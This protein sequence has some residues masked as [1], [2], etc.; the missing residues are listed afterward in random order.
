MLVHYCLPKTINLWC[1]RKV[2]FMSK[3]VLA[4]PRG[5]LFVL[6]AGILWST[7]GVAVNYMY[8]STPTTA[9][10]ILYYRF[11]F[12][13]PVL[14]MLLL[15][16]GVFSPIKGPD[17]RAMLVMGSMLAASQLCY[18][19]A[20]REI[21]VAVATLIAICVP[22]I[23]VALAS[24]FLFK[25]ALTK[26]VLTALCLAALG[27]FLLIGFEKASEPSSLWGVVI[28]LGSAATFAAVILAGR[29]LAGYDR[30]LQANAVTIGFGTLLLTPIASTLGI[31]TSFTA[32][33]WS[34][35]VY[36]GVVTTALSYWLFVEG[37]RS[38]SA[39]EASILTLIDPLV[40]TA[41]AY[42]L[43]DERLEPT[44]LIGAALLL[45]AFVIIS[46]R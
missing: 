2:F 27:V 11:L 3:R 43:I 13:T 44:G 35:L 31:G 17:L 10:T 32:L 14:V 4:R 34:L 28:A 1:L 45:A 23:F 20:L 12:A 6:A 22:P 36:L 41:L 37:M 38:V 42:L 9:L 7:I 33:G 40:A 29:S 8:A 39:T 25:E 30:P 21:G 15:S 26:A 19:A 46:R 24:T 5:V 16:R 18:F